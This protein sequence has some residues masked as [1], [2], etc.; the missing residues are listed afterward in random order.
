VYQR[1]PDSSFAVI[2]DTGGG[3]NEVRTFFENA[4]DE[5]GIP[6]YDPPAH[7]KAEDSK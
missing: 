2:P 4:T 7:L 5:I 1:D 3:H 6:I